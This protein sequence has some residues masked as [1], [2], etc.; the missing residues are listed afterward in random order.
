MEYGLPIDPEN[1]I[2]VISDPRTHKK[3]IVNEGTPEEYSY[4]LIKALDFKCEEGTPIKA[5]LEGKVVRIVN[6]MTA[7]WNQWREPTRREI[8]EL[9]QGPY[10]P[11]GNFAA[12]EHSDGTFT[13]YSHLMNGS[14]R[15]QKGDYVKKGQIIAESG[16]TGHSIKPHLHYVRLKFLH[17]YP[18][19][20]FISLDTPWSPEAAKVIKEKWRESNAA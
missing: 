14:L 13:T 12:I 2:V 19:R 9:E 4:D 1:I 3:G 7:N 10:D 15:V 20:D 11:D 8:E 5:A 6:G 17:P 18:V 16:N